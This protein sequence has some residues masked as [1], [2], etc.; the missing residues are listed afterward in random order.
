MEKRCDILQ[1]KL[2]EVDDG[3]NKYK[4]MSKSTK[5]FTMMEV[6][7]VADAKN[8]SLDLELT[9][10]E[11]T[12]YVAKTKRDASHLREEFQ[13]EAVLKEL[14]SLKNEIALLRDRLN[15]IEIELTIAES[16]VFG[17]SARQ[18]KLVKDAMQNGEIKCLI[19]SK[20]LTPNGIST[21]WRLMKIMSKTLF[22]TRFVRWPMCP[23]HSII[24]C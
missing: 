6:S 24:S 13:L 4:K 3:W 7:L 11:H 12:T 1:K 10:E 15:N 9:K 18:A 22:L 21:F 23:G 14:N 19:L 2:K 20:A 16:S 8:I 5:A 17:V